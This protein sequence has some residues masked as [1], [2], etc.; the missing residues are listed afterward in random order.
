MMRDVLWAS[1][2]AQY[3]LHD[4]WQKKMCFEMMAELWRAGKSR[5]VKDIINAKN[6][7]ERLALK[8]DCI[9]SDV[10]WRAFVAKKISK[11]HLDIRAKCQERRKKVVPHTLSRRGYAQ[12]IDD[13]KKENEDGKISRIDAFRRAHTK[14]NGEPVNPTTSDIFLSISHLIFV[15]FYLFSI[16]H[17]L[18]LLIYMPGSLNE[19]L[20]EDPKSGTTDNADEDALTKLFGN[21]KSGRLIGQGRGVARS[22]L[23]VVNMCNSKISKLEEEQHNMK[24][25]MTEM[26]NLL[27]EHLVGGKVTPS[28]GQSRNVPQS[29]N[30]QSPKSIA[31]EKIHNF[32]EGKNAC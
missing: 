11:E 28:E 1:I 14:K 31:L 17:T 22:K 2:Q 16:M 23:T 29:N 12:T 18:V 19:I 20:L 8:L 27:K 21:P 7:S 9:K 5:L 4:D 3:D 10:E 24:L 32:T 25:E 6:E 26:M 30:I 15:N 13:M